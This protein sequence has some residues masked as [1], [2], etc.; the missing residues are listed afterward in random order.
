MMN[1]PTEELATAKQLWRL[2][3][4]G[5]LPTPCW[6]CGA[7][8]CGVVTLEEARFVLDEAEK[9]GLWTKGER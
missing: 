8:E 2:N 1:T 5:L 3:Q 4:L 7:P 9:K 6:Q